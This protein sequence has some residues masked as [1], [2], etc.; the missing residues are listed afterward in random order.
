MVSR[1]PCPQAEPD[2]YVEY[3]SRFGMPITPQ[4]AVAAG[5]AR[6]WFKPQFVGLEN[7]PDQPALLIGNHA[8][9]VVAAMRVRFFLSVTGM[10]RV[11]REG[12]VGGVIHGGGSLSAKSCFAGW[13]RGVARR[14]EGGGN[15]RVCIAFGI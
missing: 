8:F 10:R 6:A 12:G 3:V 13:V 11:A 15:A 5:L 2:A 4:V 14:A 9:M 1:S 7:L